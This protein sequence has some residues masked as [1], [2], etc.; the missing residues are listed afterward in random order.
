MLKMD[1]SKPRNKQIMSIKKNI[2]IN[3]RE[4][5]RERERG[6]EERERDERERER[7][8]ER[9]KELE[10]ELELENFISKDSSLGL[11]RPNN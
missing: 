11:F 1:T 6:E 2:Y 9:K 5:E 7:E 4:R 8:R 3:Q 10:L